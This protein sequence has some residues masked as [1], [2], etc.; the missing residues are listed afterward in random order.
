MLATLA[1]LVFA[2]SG[3][4]DCINELNLRFLS[5]VYTMRWLSRGSIAR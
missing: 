2:D 3:L 4:L 5:T 1:R